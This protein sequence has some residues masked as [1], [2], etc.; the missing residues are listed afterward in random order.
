MVGQIANIRKAFD[1]VDKLM[2]RAEKSVAARAGRGA[3]ERVAIAKRGAREEADAHVRATEQWTKARQRIIDNSAKYAGRIAAQEASKEV[4]EKERAE[5]KKTQL[6][7]HAERERTR[8]AERWARQRERIQTNSAV[9]AGRAA[10]RAAAQEARDVE[11]ART[12]RFNSRRDIVNRGTGIVGGSVRGLVGG[13]A[14][15][16]GA[17]VAL[18]GGFTLADTV[19]R[20]FGA[21]SAAISLSNSAFLGK[22][23]RPSP[24][25]ILSRAR[26]VAADTGIG[27]A[28][29]IEGW[30]SYVA[31]SSDFA[32]GEK[33]LG[34]LAKLAKGSGSKFG[35]VMSAA[36][37]LRTQNADMTPEEMMATMRNVVAQGKLGAVELPDLAQ[38]AGKVTAS[39][40]MYGDTRSAAEKAS[41]ANA[42]TVA[43][44]KLLGLSQIAIKTSGSPE[45][46]ATS[47]TRF[48]SD[49][50]SHQKGLKKTFGLDV[51]DAKTGLL[52]DP[53]EVL[54]MMFTKA[55][56]HLGKLGEM[57]LGDR[58]IKLAEALAPVYQ[59]AEARK[60][61]SGGD[62]IRAEVNKFTSVGYT[63]GQVNED[64][65]AVMAAKGE[66]FGLAVESIK[67]VLEGKLTPYLSRLADR[68]PEL[69]PKIE[70]IIDG[71]AKL[72]DFFIEN[73]FTGIGAIVLATITKDIVMA[74]IG[75]AVQ[76]ALVRLIA[77]SA[78]GL[79]GGG[80]ASA[81]AGVGGG[82]GS[83]L[84]AAAPAAGVL[85]IGL[86]GVAAA[87]VEGKMLIDSAAAG[88]ASGQQRAGELLASAKWATSKD[89]I[90][91]VQKEL[92]GADKKSGFGGAMK[93]AFGAMSIGGSTLAS[94]V[95]GK[96]NQALKQVESYTQARAIDS[97]AD[98]IAKALEKAA[99]RIN[100]AGGP[101]GPTA[102][103]AARSRPM[104]SFERGG[105]K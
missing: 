51:A 74:G 65:A 14:N 21:E 62:A 102:S 61:G 38:I 40:A 92:A 93:A 39:S 59:T 10:V 76:A 9:A 17:A 52:K 70:R 33:N 49:V 43:Q 83:K 77:G 23:A 8:S 25:A 28:E 19:Q 104:L 91:A 16:A 90:S 81:V 80:G 30:Q 2:V 78:P 22:G 15:L 68:L 47:I 32:G 46:A 71:A 75:G 86:A 54:A 3:R 63:P 94:L 4:R 42:Q 44:R 96:E 48:G 18:G 66:R 20:S 45:E 73:P 56:G 72:A 58:S 12:T 82:V 27:K 100:D 11:R 57:G 84:L 97:K 60:K 41:G 98:E 64:F 69:M 29:L 37:W 34:D 99:R 103:N 6:A 87:G 13:A 36:G 79:V 67:E 89:D 53:A 35:D 85:G 105:T 24:D 55:G 1:D 101:D 26:G 88:A 5:Q 31:K 7:E 50:L 95:T